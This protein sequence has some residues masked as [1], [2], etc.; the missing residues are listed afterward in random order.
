MA[1]EHFMPVNMGD[2]TTFKE[3]FSQQYGGIDRESG[4][5]EHATLQGN[6]WIWLAHPKGNLHISQDFIAYE[7]IGDYGQMKDA[8]AK[9]MQDYPQANDYYNL[10]LTDPSVTPMEKNRTW[11]LVKVS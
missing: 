2:Y 7:I 8:Y 1:F 4:M 6:G 11:I 3:E 10:Y 5:L 9:I